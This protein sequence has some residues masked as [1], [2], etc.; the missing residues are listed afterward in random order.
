M[1]GGELDTLNRK[2]A[3]PEKDIDQLLQEFLQ[4]LPRQQT[5]ELY[6]AYETAVFEAGLSAAQR[7]LLF[8]AALAKLPAASR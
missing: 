6:R 1:I 8:C 4:A 7:R 2:Q 5:A 3:G